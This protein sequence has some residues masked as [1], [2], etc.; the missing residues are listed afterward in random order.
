MTCTCCRDTGW[1]CEAHDDRP[2]HGEGACGCGEPGMPC[3]SCN[4]SNEDNPP[5][6]L[7]GLRSD[8]QSDE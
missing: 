7:P 6:L 4:V 5:R 1:V 3:S 2:W 8:E